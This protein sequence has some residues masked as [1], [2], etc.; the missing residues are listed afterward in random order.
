MSTTH[1]INIGQAIA[2]KIK[3]RY[4]EITERT[5]GST[6]MVVDA[7][8]P[9]YVRHSLVG[10]NNQQY[11]RRLS[12][13]ASAISPFI[14]NEL[15]VAQ[16]P[17]DDIIRMLGYRKA[18]ISHIINRVKAKEIDLTLAGL[19][20][21][22]M[23]FFH[24]AE[25]ICYYTNCVNV[26]KS[27]E[28][29]DADFVDITNIF[30]FPR[31]INPEKVYGLGLYANLL[32][33][34]MVN[35]YSVLSVSTISKNMSFIEAANIK[36]QGTNLMKDRFRNRVFY[37]APDIAS[38]E[39]FAEIEDMKFVSGTHGD[40]DCQLY[41]KPMQDS[42]LQ[43][44]SYG[45]INLSVFFMNQV[46]LT[47]AFLELLASDTD[48][49]KPNLVMEYSFAKEYS[50]DRITSSGLTRTYNFPIVENNVLDQEVATPELP[51]MEEIGSIEVPEI[52]E[53]QTPPELPPILDRTDEYINALFQ[54]ASV[55]SAP[56]VPSDFIREQMSYFATRMPSPPVQPSYR[57]DTPNASATIPNYRDAYDMIGSL[58]AVDDTVHQPDEADIG[59][60]AL[61][62]SDLNDELAI[63]PNPTPTIIPIVRRRRR[64]PAEMAAAR[65]SA[66]ISPIEVEL[67]VQENSAGIPF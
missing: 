19:G 27:I 9:T 14:A 64:T 37:G 30:R 47:I 40:D 36:I 8:Y 42:T 33:C 65:A 5:L 1:T 44:E 28:I 17:F 55:P 6:N 26:F 21:T 24:W 13:R 46:K 49:T 41:I 16:V 2:D 35:S 4:A 50:N 38:R 23:N 18:D 54:E 7:F 53:I 51:N 39:A 32:K 45:M 25:E 60:A 15:N 66:G 48:L 61:A 63:V 20:G 34:D 29:Y 67:A 57:Y 10:T 59:E 12:K 31:I 11:G 56:I 62:E 3:V 43:V 52:T 58:L 22:G